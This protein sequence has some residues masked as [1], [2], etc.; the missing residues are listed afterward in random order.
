[1]IPQNLELAERIYP[2]DTLGFQGRT[3]TR[4]GRYL[5]RRCMLSFLLLALAVASLGVASAEVEVYAP[6]NRFA[7]GEDATLNLYV[8]NKDVEPVGSVSIEVQERWGAPIEVRT[9][10]RPVGTVSDLRGPIP[11]DIVV[12]E[13]VRPRSHTLRL[14]VSWSEQ[15]GDRTI[16][17]HRRMYV[18]VEIASIA[19]FDVRE[20]STQA[21]IGDTGN[22]T[23]VLENTGDEAAYDPSVL[24]SSP[25]PEV[26]FVSGAS[27]TDTYVGE[28]IVGESREVEYQLRV[29]DDAQP[30][31]YSIR[32]VVE[33]RDGSGVDETSRQLRTGVTAVERQ[34]FLVRNVSSDLS[35][36]SRG[37]V[38]GELYNPGPEDAS[39]VV[40]VYETPNPNVNPLD[41][42]YA[43]GDVPAGEAEEFSFRVAVGREATPGI[44]EL[45][46][47]PR[48]RNPDGDFRAADTVDVRVDVDERVEE[49][50][51]E[52]VDAS[53]PQ[54]GEDVVSLEVTNTGD[55]VYE[56]LEAMVFVSRPLE[57]DDPEAFVDRLEPGESSEMS[58]RVSAGREAIQRDYPLSVDFRYTDERGES[59]LSD[60]Y[61]VAVT[62]V[63]PSPWRYV[64]AAA[65]LLLALMA[66]VG[67]IWWRRR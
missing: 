51:V 61:R 35:I 23:L 55:E 42:E 60:T 53:V 49:F 52:A 37:D 16:D 10:E 67:Y 11:F 12:D 43:L 13:D 65:L 3:D 22:M 14:D 26:S 44:R 28:W 38:E 33:F 27:F 1:M 20:A 32:T 7:P 64:A 57:T 50:Q 39:D 2:R 36:D 21:R 56:D 9:S 58:F 41:P 29:E 45:T 15:V 31:D 19:R 48:Y 17:R 5:R 59:Q 25:D 4:M 46:M 63:E 24:V 40:L 8:D 54:G 6:E 34:E 62:V 66:G 18:D 47:L 30:R